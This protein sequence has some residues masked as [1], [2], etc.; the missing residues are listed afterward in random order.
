[1][2]ALILYNDKSNPYPLEIM[3]EMNPNRYVLPPG[4]EMEIQADPAGG[5]FV[6]TPYEGGLQIHAGNI[7]DPVVTIDGAAVEA[8]WGTPTPDSK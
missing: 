1:M 8:D 5:S 4:S 2:P 3:I 7:F 6:V